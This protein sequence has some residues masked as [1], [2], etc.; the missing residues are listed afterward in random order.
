M[1]KQQDRKLKR[2]ISERERYRGKEQYRNKILQ[3]KKTRYDENE[4]YREEK[5][6]TSKAT[7][8]DMYHGNEQYRGKRKLPVKLPV[9]T[10]IIKIQG[11]EIK[12]NLLVEGNILL[13]MLH[14]NLQ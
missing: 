5:K 9:W 13:A 8:M 4:Q 14:T 2:R 3:A 11:I 12:R 1:T 6:A 7:S 10:C